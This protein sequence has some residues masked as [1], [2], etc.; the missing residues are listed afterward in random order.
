MSADEHW[1][2]TPPMAEFL[3]LYPM[4]GTFAWIGLAE[5]AFEDLAQ[6][7][8]DTSVLVEIALDTTARKEACE[9]WTAQHPGG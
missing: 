7:E 5:Q 2:S 3:H 6:G 1:R 9:R 8:Q 4:V